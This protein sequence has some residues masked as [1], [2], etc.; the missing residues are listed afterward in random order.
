MTNE[1]SMAAGLLALVLFLAAADAQEPRRQDQKPQGNTKRIT[2]LVDAKALADP[3]AAAA[4]AALL[5][6][7]YEGQ[8]PPEAVRMLAA[9]L[10]GSQMGAG[11]GWFGPAQTRYSWKWLADRCGVDPVKGEIPRKRFP[12]SDVLFARLD[13]D[14]N[15]VISPDDFDWSD[16][17]PYVQMSYMANRLFRKLNAEG[18]GRLTKDELLQFFDKAAQGKDHLS[19]D[20]F[21]DALL[22]GLF[23]RY[24]PSDMP[25]QA[26]LIRGL[27]AGELGSMNEG[28]KLN[29]PAPDFTLKTVDGKETIQL[30]KRFAAKPVILV[31][32][33]FT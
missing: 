4:A 12:G 15:G 14:K 3:K 16:R 6:S 2:P 25:S 17:S 19:A 7:A 32:G 11:E 5:E 21:R 10:R 9:V 27:F 8:T 18:N 20:D 1:K 23:R 31:F 26:V 13:R 33:S 22:G 28:P 30:A 24:Q 29:D